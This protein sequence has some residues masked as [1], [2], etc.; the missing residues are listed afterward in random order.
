MYVCIW[1]KRASKQDYISLARTYFILFHSI[2]FLRSIYLFIYL[3]STAFSSPASSIFE[4]GGEGLF[5]AV[6]RDSYSVG[7]VT[8]TPLGTSLLHSIEQHSTVNT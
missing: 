5:V 2:L 6:F 4:E 8:V 1:R 7:T 3:P